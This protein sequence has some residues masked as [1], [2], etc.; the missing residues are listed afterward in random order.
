MQVASEAKRKAALGKNRDQKVEQNLA[1]ANSKMKK[2]QAEQNI[3]I[4]VKF[5][6]LICGFALRTVALTERTSST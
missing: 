1:R 5:A 3:R 4:F 6:L 2:I